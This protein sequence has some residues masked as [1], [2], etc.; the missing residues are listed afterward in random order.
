MAAPFSDLQSKAEAA[1]KLTLEDVS[2]SNRGGAT[3]VTGLGTATLA[4][5]WIEATVDPG[6]EDPPHTGNFWLTHTITVKSDSGDGITNH[7]SR[8]A[9]VIDAIM[10]DTLPTTLSGKVA[11]Y[12]CQGIRNRRVLPQRQEERTLITEIQFDGI[13]CPSDL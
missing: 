8:V 6:E 5:P 11:D 4:L 12:A 7:R 10:V 13:C 3:V 1:L 2:S 9:Y